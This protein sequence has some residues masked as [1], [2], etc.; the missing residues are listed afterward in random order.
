[1]KSER[2]PTK[3]MKAY[4]GQ[5]RREN[6]QKLHQVVAGSKNGGIVIAMG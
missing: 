6:P 4:L 5:L 3:K 1:M 2:K